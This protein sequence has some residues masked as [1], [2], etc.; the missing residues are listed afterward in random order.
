MVSPGVARALLSARQTVPL[1]L[2][3]AL[4]VFPGVAEAE[5]GVV[6]RQGTMIQS[7]Y[8]ELAGVLV[9]DATAPP[10]FRAGGKEFQLFLQDLE[11]DIPNFVNKMPII[12]K[13][14]AGTLSLPGQPTRH[15]FWP[16]SC[17]IRT[18]TY[19]FPD[20]TPI[21]QEWLVNLGQNSQL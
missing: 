15:L 19:T 3:L 13:G 6:W 1:V 9:L 20:P 12:M 17:T 5:G 7:E 16:M 8:E 4:V 10:V 21:H 11:S 18:Q 14:I 2:L